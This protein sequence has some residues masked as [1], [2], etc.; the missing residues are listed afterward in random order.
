MSKKKSKQTYSPEVIQT[1]HERLRKLLT[2]YE[3]LS[4]EISY[5]DN[6]IKV[7]G[8]WAESLP[9]CEEQKDHERQKESWQIAAGRINQ[10][11][12]T[13]NTQICYIADWLLE[14]DDAPPDDVLEAAISLIR[15]IGFGLEMSG[16]DA[17]DVY[18]FLVLR[19]GE[20]EAA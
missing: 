14:F 11:M 7:Y 18:P 12:E 4:E 8:E 10:L 1:T 16:L 15:N 17:C 9:I 6:E 5:A 3:V 20:A 2:I 19:I 13:F